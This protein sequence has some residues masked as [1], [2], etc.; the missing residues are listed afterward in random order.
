METKIRKNGAIIRQ[1]VVKWKDSN[2]RIRLHRVKANSSGKRRKSDYSNNP[3]DLPAPL[4]I[5]NEETGVVYNDFDGSVTTVGLR[6]KKAS[7]LRVLI[8]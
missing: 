8:D 3:S 4:G 6:Q 7:S 1:R 2:G 5:E